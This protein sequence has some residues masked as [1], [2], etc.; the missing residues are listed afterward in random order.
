MKKKS[1][2][3]ITHFIAHLTTTDVNFAQNFSHMAAFDSKSMTRSGKTYSAQLVIKPPYSHPIFKMPRS[4]MK[5]EH[6]PDEAGWENAFH[7]KC[8]GGF[9]NCRCFKGY[10][11]KET[12]E[13]SKAQHRIPDPPGKQ[14]FTGKCTYRLCGR[15]IKKKDVLRIPVDGFVWYGCFCSVECIEGHAIDLDGG[16]F[17]WPYKRFY[18][19][20]IK[21]SSSE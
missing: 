3:F 21:Q 13:A 7:P 16:Y 11:H 14:W 10:I 9:Y 18:H 12:P 15:N 19:I 20:P 6:K 5:V 17:C 2:L 4:Q 1:Y 8:D